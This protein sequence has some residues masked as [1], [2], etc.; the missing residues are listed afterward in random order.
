M[1]LSIQ[2][3]AKVKYLAMSFEL[4]EINISG[5]C[6]GE[7]GGVEYDTKDKKLGV[8]EGLLTTVA[9]FPNETSVCEV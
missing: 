2:K 5:E 9:L 7:S 3:S 4:R 1:H 6:N 8:T